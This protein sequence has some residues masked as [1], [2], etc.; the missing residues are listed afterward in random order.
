M[1]GQLVNI[2]GNGNRI[3]CLAIGPR[4]VYVIAE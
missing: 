3:A 1:D 2:D 4:Y